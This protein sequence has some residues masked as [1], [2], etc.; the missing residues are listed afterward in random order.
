[1]T[2]T[3][4]LRLCDCSKTYHVLNAAEKVVNFR[5]SR[6]FKVEYDNGGGE[7]DMRSKEGKL[8][9]GRALSCSYLQA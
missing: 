8:A 9:S 6:K 1:M 4:A 2:G 5:A 3:L 7:C